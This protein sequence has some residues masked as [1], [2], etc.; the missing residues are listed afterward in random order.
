MGLGGGHVSS[1]GITRLRRD[2]RGDQKAQK[3]GNAGKCPQL[4][5]SVLGWHEKG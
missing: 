3:G 1:R 2:G 5:E 4:H